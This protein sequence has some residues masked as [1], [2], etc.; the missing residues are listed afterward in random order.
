MEPLPTSRSKSST[1][2]IILAGKYLVLNYKK[3]YDKQGLPVA[4]NLL[5]AV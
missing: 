2:N 4:R 3:V 1:G 5:W